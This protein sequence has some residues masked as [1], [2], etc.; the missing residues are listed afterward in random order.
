MEQSRFK[1]STNKMRD[2]YHLSDEALVSI[3]EELDAFDA[4]AGVDNSSTAALSPPPPATPAP[5]P[6]PIGKFGVKDTDEAEILFLGTGSSLPSKARNVSA[7]Y[8][9]TQHEGKTAG[10]LLDC[11]EGT[12]GQL[13]SVFQNNMEERFR[14]T[15][16]IWISHP[17]ADHHLGLLEFHFERAKFKKKAGGGGG[18]GGD[19]RLMLIAPNCILSW[20]KF[21]VDQYGR[22]HASEASSKE[23]LLRC[24]CLARRAAR[25]VHVRPRRPQGGFGGSPPDNPLACPLP[26][27]KNS[28][29]LPP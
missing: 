16:A 8:V 28:P 18:G 7:I 12:T 4:E 17:H 23:V 3:N 15:R 20:V 29:S 1:S 14:G 10:M 6:A 9:S 22:E 21:F 11:G 27:R 24:C 19:E 13:A 26:P 5:P 2:T 25:G